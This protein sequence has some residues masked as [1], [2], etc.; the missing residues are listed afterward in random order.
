MNA[1]QVR[2]VIQI[3]ARLA[4]GRAPS[5]AMVLAVVGGFGASQLYKSHQSYEAGAPPGVLGA[6]ATPSDCNSLFLKGLRPRLENE[7]AA[8][9]TKNLCYSEFSVGHSALTRTALW[10]AEHL[11]PASVRAAKTIKRPEGSLFHTEPQ[12]PL[13]EAATP[14]DYAHSGRDRGHLTP[15]G[16]P[17]TVKAKKETF[18]MANMIPQSQKLNRGSWAH[19]EDKVRHLAEKQDNL[20][21]VTG[22]AFIGAKIRVLN[23]RVAEPTHVWKAVTNGV[24]STVYWVENKDDGRITEISLAELREKAKVVAFPALVQ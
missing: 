9:S 13:D 6:A 1:S 10:S 8:S 20:Y 3:A 23:G 15:S 21:V 7:R 22:P 4:R 2:A 14:Q 16:D 12:V 24:W 17:S 18:T 11:T 19:L 5:I